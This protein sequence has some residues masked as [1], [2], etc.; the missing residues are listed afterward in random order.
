MQV[1]VA[2]SCLDAA[3]QKASSQPFAL[4]FRVPD[5]LFGLAGS[6][7]R[8]RLATRQALAK[9]FWPPPPPGGRAQ[10]QELPFLPGLRRVIPADCLRVGNGD[11]SGGDPLGGHINISIGH[12][13][14]S[15]TI[16]SGFLGTIQGL[17]ACEDAFQSCFSSDQADPG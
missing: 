11:P 17:S 5:C 15:E 8:A 13:W 14:L 10:D 1:D 3:R 16:A 12:S 9:G 4:L 6:T 2:I 7:S